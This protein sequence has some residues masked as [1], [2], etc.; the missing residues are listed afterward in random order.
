MNPLTT[1]EIFE[2]MKELRPRLEAAIQ[3]EAAI[4]ADLPGLRLQRDHL[5]AELERAEANAFLVAKS[6]KATDETAKRMAKLDPKVREAE[7]AYSEAVEAVRSQV[8]QQNLKHS[9]TKAWGG[10][11][12]SNGALSWALNKELKAFASEVH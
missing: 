8:D 2:Q 9:E 10:L 12:E 1:R 4:A 6:Q 3:H 11:V 7:Q 5:K